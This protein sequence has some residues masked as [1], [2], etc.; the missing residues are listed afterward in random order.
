MLLAPPKG[1]VTPVVLARAL[2][3][4]YQVLSTS[5]LHVATC[6][7]SVSKSLWIK[8]GGRIM[9]ILTTSA[10][11]ACAHEL[12]V[13]SSGASA[14]SSLPSVT[15][16]RFSFLVDDV[17]SVEVVLSQIHVLSRLVLHV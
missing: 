5:G 9:H 2:S 16:I 1:V 17:H 4:R 13:D 6:W 10:I 8:I 3:T 14:S 15:V 12:V 7:Q 11:L